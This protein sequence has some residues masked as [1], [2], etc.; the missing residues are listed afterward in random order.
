M[1]TYH[2]PAK[3]EWASYPTMVEGGPKPK[4]VVI[5]LFR[6]VMLTKH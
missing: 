1:S 6:N 2:R 4:R 5:L 3:K